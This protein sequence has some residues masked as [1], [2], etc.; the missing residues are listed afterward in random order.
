MKYISI[1]LEYIFKDSPLRHLERYANDSSVFVSARTLVQMYY[2]FLLFI[3][4]ALFTWDTSFGAQT[5]IETPWP[6][7]WIPFVG[8]VAA[9]TFVR[10]FF[11]AASVLA[12]W[13]PHWRPARILSFVALFEFCALYISILQL[14]VDGYGLLLTSLLFIFLPLG[15]EKMDAPVVVRMKFLLVFFAVQVEN[16]LTYTM[17]GIGKLYGAAVQIAAGQSNFFS[18]HAPALQIADRQLLT[19]VHTAL[20]SWAVEHYLLIYPWY[21]F[22]LYLLLF[23]FFVAF[24]PKLHRTWGLLL[25]LFH[26][27]NYLVINI[28]FVSHIFLWSLLLLA[29]PFAPTKVSVKEFLCNLPVVDVVFK[30]ILR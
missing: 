14:D 13:K 2:F 8:F 11:I 30:K 20:G 29:S 15:Y 12:A 3:S 10:I 23:S 19:G 25:I 22:T 27:G 4:V 6:I 28:G 18:L 9:Y 21:L 24:R 16:L 7:G 5:Q 1:L 17:G 26:V